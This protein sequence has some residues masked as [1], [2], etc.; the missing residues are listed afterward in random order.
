MRKKEII[1]HK[2]YEE[3]KKLFRQ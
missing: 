1:E 2:R 3:I